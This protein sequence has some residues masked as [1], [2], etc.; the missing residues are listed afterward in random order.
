MK[1]DR[2]VLFP[3]LAAFWEIFVVLSVLQW[4]SFNLLNVIGFF[5]LTIVPGLV[6]SLSIKSTRALPFWVRLGQIVGLSLLSEI[7]WLLLCNTVL[8]HFNVPRPLDRIPIIIE[9]T[10]LNFVIGAWGWHRLKRFSY[11]IQ[12]KTAREYGLYGAASFGPFVFVALSVMGAV[13]L[14]NGSTNLFTMIMLVLSCTYL[15]VLIVLRKHLADSSIAWALY[16]ISLSLL[17]MTSMRSWYITGHDIQ[18]EYLV[19]RMTISHG[20]WNI[21]NFRDP[22]NSCLSTTILPTLF[23]NTLQIGSQ[24][25]YKILF[26]II[27]AVVPV[28]VYQI[29]RLYASKA[30]SILAVIY[31]ISFPT[32]FTDMSFLNRQ[33]IAFLFLGLMLLFALNKYISPR[34][35]ELLFITFGIG[36]IASH[37]STTYAMLIVLLSAVALRMSI[38]YIFRRRRKWMRLFDHSGV[39]ILRG[40]RHGLFAITVPAVLTL[41]GVAFVWNVVLTDTAGGAVSL[42]TQITDTLRNGSSAGTRSND[43]S[44]SL[45]APKAAKPQQLINGYLHTVITPK[46]TAAPKGTFYPKSATTAFKVTASPPSDTPLTRLGRILA[47]KR[48]NVYLLNFTFKQ[49]SA[50]LVQV[51]AIA[52]LCY[53]LLFDGF[54][55]SIDNDYLTLSLGSGL[56][57]V[58]QLVIP[59]LS[60]AYG[61]LRAFQQA[62]MLFGMFLVSG[63]FAV[64]KIFRNIK[65]LRMAVPVIIALGFFLSST[66][67]MSELLGGYQAQLHL[68][69]SGTYFDEYYMHA[70]ELAAD[71]WLVNTVIKKDPHAS[72]QT[73]LDTSIRLDSATGYQSQNDIMPNQIETYSYVLLGYNDTVNRQA[74]ISYDGNTIAYNYPIQFL[75]T[76]KNLIY[77]NGSSEVYR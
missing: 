26:Q 4:N 19:F 58:T 49:T 71:H 24:Y 51:L 7:L 56:F 77:S 57:I 33:E 75:N 30:K 35:R 15:G 1:I 12:E 43:V 6:I 63:T 50:K 60:E 23:Y 59:F 10:V 11:V 44:Y 34:K 61:L 69:N 53:I 25:V 29:M 73:D 45:I 18:H 65:P 42:I 66:G 14:N 52:G 5:Y 55:R 9:L 31:F 27:F 62:L 22:Y 67:V 13:S 46:V 16:F 41:V 37:Y 21:A 38:L 47:T 8:P 3:L 76:N 64:A 54:G 2:V 68:N 48:I 28:V 39:A 32:Y 20:D 72:V 74:Y 40:R 70:Q 36:V 17:L